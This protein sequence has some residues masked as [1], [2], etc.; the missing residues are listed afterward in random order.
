VL[1]A[2]LLQILKRGNENYIA[3]FGMK[4]SSGF[5]PLQILKRGNENYIA[6][7]GMKCSSGFMFEVTMNHIHSDTKLSTHS[8]TSECGFR[9]L[10]AGH[11]Q[12]C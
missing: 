9:E 4:C 5:M 6:I 12:Q 3:I 2:L 7:F 11:I 1:S 10:H 8:T